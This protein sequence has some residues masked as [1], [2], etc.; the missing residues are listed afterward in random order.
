MKAFV[1]FFLLA[2]PLAGCQHVVP[3]KS[4]IMQPP[5]ASPIHGTINVFYPEELRSYRCET[6]NGYL[7]DNFQLELGTQSVTMFDLVLEGLFEH[8]NHI[9][10]DPIFG[11]TIE[12]YPFIKFHLIRFTGCQAAWPIIGTTAIEIEYMASIYTQSGKV[13]AQIKAGGHADK[14][15]LLVTDKET[16]YFDEASYLASL[17]RVAMRK[18]VANFVFGFQKNEEIYEALNAEGSS[19]R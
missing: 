10:Y 8:V 6:G 2:F 7:F 11:G 14:F 4:P 16:K 5:L 3:I 13:I 15:D 1:S 18:A 9:G 12:K 19:L 17:T